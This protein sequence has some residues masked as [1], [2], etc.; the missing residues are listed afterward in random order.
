MAARAGG[1]TLRGLRSFAARQPLNLSHSS[2]GLCTYRPASSSLHHVLRTLALGVPVVGG[3]LLLLYPN[4][5]SPVPAILAS[6]N[7]IP[8]P[9]DTTSPQR[10]LLT[11]QMSSPNEDH[12]SILRRILDF[13]RDRIWE[14][15]RTG[16][17]FLHLFTLFMPVIITSPMLF[18][19]RLPKNKR[20]E[21]WGAIWWYG[22]LVA[23]MQR[24][25]PTFIKVRSPSYMQ[26]LHWIHALTLL[27]CPSHILQ[28]A[29]WAGSRQDL[30]SAKLCE[31]LGSLHSNG[32]LHSF[33]HTQRVIEKAFRRPFSEVFQSFDHEPIGVGAIA[34]VYR[35]VLDP[36]L[37]PM[38][39][40]APKSLSVIQRKTVRDA[41]KDSPR[42]LADITNPNDA[43]PP[44]VPTSAVAIKILHPGVEAS[45]RRDLAIMSFFA[46]CLNIIPGIEWLSLKEEIAVFG[47]MMNEQLDLRV[48]AANL[49]TFEKNFAGRRSAVTFPRPLEDFS[50]KDVLVEEYQEA[51][52][53]NAFLRNGGGPYDQRLAN[54][55]LDAF[56]VSIGNTYSCG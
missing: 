42:T 6:L 19:G 52:P 11:H 13:L 48:E 28:L 23:Q 40:L 50:N 36:L 47:Q 46:S 20:G 22:F 8:C 38:S 26:L 31:R 10:T 2:R 1:S 27:D 25:G 34:Q 4:E 9:G 15:F 45:I 32:R 49:R 24:A 12:K 33:A 37:L 39:Y 44:I 21:R 51:L 54:L 41:I 16:M 56:L 5:E 18:V 17:R 14:P 43:H 53:L 55:G 7:V 30:F 29:Q 3:G 35:A